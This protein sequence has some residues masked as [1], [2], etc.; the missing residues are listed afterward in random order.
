MESIPSKHKAGDVLPW[1]PLPAKKQYEQV[2]QG[3]Y[4]LLSNK[5]E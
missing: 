3:A 4:V 1:K 5:F 2:M